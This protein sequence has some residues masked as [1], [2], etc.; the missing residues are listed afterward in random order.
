MF[1]FFPFISVS[2]LYS[3]DFGSQNV[4]IGVSS[5]GKSIEIKLNERDQRSTPNYL[6]L[7]L[8]DP[9]FH[10]P[11]AHWHIG[12]EAERIT[13]RNSSYGIRNPFAVYLALIT[14]FMEFHSLT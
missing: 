10:F 9:L 3:I 1:L 11:E 6:S 14:I 12:S 4:R 8:S 13:R 2:A 5:P 7:S